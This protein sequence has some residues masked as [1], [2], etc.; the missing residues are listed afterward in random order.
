MAPVLLHTARETDR[1][2]R[3]HVAIALEDAHRYIANGCHRE[4]DQP[5]SRQIMEVYSASDHSTVAEALQICNISILC[6]TTRLATLSV[7]EAN[8]SPS[9]TIRGVRDSSPIISH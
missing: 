1:V 4:S 7:R 8:A 2:Q 6:G 5:T 3:G 9:R